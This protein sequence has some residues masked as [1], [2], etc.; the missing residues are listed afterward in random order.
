[1]ED[2]AFT[3]GLLLGLAALTMV[4]GVFGAA[5][6]LKF[7]HP[8]VSYRQPDWLY[9]HGVGFVHSIGVGRYDFLCDS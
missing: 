3:H 5:Y 4:F 7:V 2:V 6:N 8:L 1:M 9:D